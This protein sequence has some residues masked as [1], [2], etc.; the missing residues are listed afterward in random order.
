MARA[1]LPVAS[2]WTMCAIEFGAIMRKP[3]YQRIPDPLLPDLKN[4]PADI[5]PL[6]D[7]REASDEELLAAARSSDDRAFAELNDRYR[8]SIHNTASRIVRNREDAEDVVQEAF[9]KAYTHLKTFRG[10]CRFSTWLTRIAVNSALMLLRK[11]R[12]RPE[13]SFQQRA[14]EDQIREIWDYPDPSPNPEQA[15]TN[16]QAFELLSRA[17][18]RLPSGYRSVMTQYLAHEQSMQQI[19]DTVG[20]SLAAT[21]SRL[22]RARLSIR[23]AMGEVIL[24]QAQGIEG[25]MRSSMHSR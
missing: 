15:Y 12:V 21:K 16:A 17:V 22:L 20:I 8:K 25:P 9:F 24:R 4:G 2:A 18:T 6:L 10:T 14:N 1:A 7:Y 13:L 19:A 11:R 3:D 23:S 5:S